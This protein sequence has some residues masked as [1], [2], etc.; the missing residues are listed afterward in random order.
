MTLKKE[1]SR[2]DAE[3][4]TS[5]KE[6]EIEKDR[7]TPKFLQ[8]LELEWIRNKTKVYYVEDID[9]IEILSKKGSTLN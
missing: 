6:L 1:I 9:E 7:L 2:A 4:Y 8:L 5:K 3:Y